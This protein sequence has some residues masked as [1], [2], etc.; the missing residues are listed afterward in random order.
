MADEHDHS[1][2]HCGL[3]VP[4]DTDYSVQ[5]GG[6][7]RAM[8]CPGCQAVAQA[9]VDAGLTDYYKHRTRDNVTAQALVPDILRE[10]DLYDRDDLQKSFVRTEA[11]NVREASLILEG[12]VC[13]ACVW[14]NERH[15]RALDGV[16]E[17]N[18]NYATHRAQVKWDNA[19]IHLSDILK[20]IAA[21]GYRAH[22]FDPNR[23]EALHKKERNAA[24]RRIA[25][26]GV[27][28]MQ[29]MMIAVGLYA[30]DYSGMSP[31]IRNFLRWVSL[32]LA[33]PVVF[34]SGRVFFLSAWR[35]LKKRQLGMDVPVSI[36]V[37][38]A[39]VASAWATVR[40]VGDVYFDSVTMF[41]F[42][43]LVGRFLELLAR[44]KAGEAGEDLIRLLPTGATRLVDGRTE[45]VTVNDLETGDRVLIR[46]GEVVPADGVVVEGTSSINEAL[47]TGE[48]LPRRRGV[49]E[50]LVGGT[51][52]VESPLQMDVTHVG[53]DTVLSSIV[54]LLDR[55]QMEKP[56]LAQLADRVAGWFV[57][58]LL[59]VA[60]GVFAFWYWYA[61]HE[62]FWI[63][64]SVLVVTCP[65]ALSLATPVALTAAT[66]TLTQLGVLTSRGHALETLSKVTHMVFDKTGTL[67]YGR[68]ELAD[69][70]VR[71]D[72]DRDTCLNI[73]AGLEQGSEHPVAQALRAAAEFPAM[74][75]DT[76]AESGRGISAMVDGRRYRLGRW[77]YVFPG[78]TDADLPT[79]PAGVS[80]VVLG[81]DD[82]LLAVFSLRDQVREEA[83]RAIERLKS[84]GIQVVLLSGDQ[85]AVA[86]RVAEEVGID[87]WSGGLLPDGKLA[88]L[89]RLQAA[90]AVTAMVG[91][92]VNDAPVL[93]GAQV[94]VAMGS[95]AQLAHASADMVLLSENLMHLSDAVEMA[96]RTLA[97]I[98]QNLAW[99]VVYNVVALPLAAAG[100]ILPWMAAV[101][102]S[103]SSLM[104]VINALRLKNPPRSM[105]SKF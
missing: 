31:D 32:L 86:A 99:A 53:G 8:C 67:T 25:V 43:L 50:E 92:G 11:E 13:A 7:R 62:A 16:L 78:K 21:I 48:S 12:I 17:F 61:P 89:R 26:A 103:A 51:L 19:Q 105:R 47:L 36:A 84:Q 9:I 46:P 29:V 91:D 33:T 39:Y 58:A 54:R 88:E 55:A 71:G 18:V 6:E 101:G 38:A 28:M 87:T 15:V 57:G 5:I 56:R 95:G 2:Y 22:P 104:V 81:E 70:E 82:R 35:D 77:E 4:P 93:A 37:G 3:P 23:Q 102:M 30:G 45:V 40:Q 69:V 34:Y 44:H 97:V 41:V 20:A 96:R 27:G 76:V 90:G 1:C 98:R 75:S 64:L 24:L 100:V 52:N 72:L 83:R 60:V 79:P 49:G 66:G 59:L 68:L 80:Q 14:L 10:Y 85:P 63:T 65:C 94:S 74:V 73:A 42:F